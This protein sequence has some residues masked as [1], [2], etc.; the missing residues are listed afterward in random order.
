LD[1]IPEH[2]DRRPWDRHQLL[3]LS[4]RLDRRRN[5]LAGKSGKQ[6][7]LVRAYR[8]RDFLIEGRDWPGQR[9]RGSG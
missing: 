2:P 6:S 8:I 3:N 4:W 9:S 1:R 5:L 7:N